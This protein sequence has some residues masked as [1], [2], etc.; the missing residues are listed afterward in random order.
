MRV[1][2]TQLFDKIIKRNGGEESFDPAKITKAILKAGEASGEFGEDVAHKLTIRVLNLALQ[3][4]SKRLPT[5]EDIQDIVEEV[6]ITSPYKKTAKN[7]IIY[8]DQHARMRETASLFNV[9]LVEKY[10]SKRDWK[11]NENSNMAYSLQG[12]NH[13]VSSEISQMYWLNKVYPKEVREAHTNGDLHIHDLGSISV[14][15]VGW[16]LYDLLTQG[17]QGASGKAESRPARHLR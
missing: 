10:L 5:V 15:C 7:Y 14:Y 17:F 8:R 6:L 4:Y 12:L 3:A 16:D 1:Y 9:D 2:T 11:V 13:Y